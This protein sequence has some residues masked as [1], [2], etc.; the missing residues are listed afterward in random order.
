M[1]VPTSG[2]TQ[3]LPQELREVSVAR[4]TDPTAVH[5]SIELLRQDVVNL[6]HRAFEV[7]RIAVPFEECCLIY[8]R[9]DVDLRTLTRVHKEFEAITVL[10][11]S[12]S[13]SLDGLELHPLALIA[14]G[15]DAQSEIVVR[16]GY[17]SVTLPGTS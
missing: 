1:N 6:G 8:Q 16:S 7:K 11:P 2:Y 17:E 3:D 5:E 10:G 9:S 15:P 14:A 4:M 13:G 12:A